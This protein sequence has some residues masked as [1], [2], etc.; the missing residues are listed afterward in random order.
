MLTR[1][2]YLAAG[3]FIISFIGL[4]L[5]GTRLRQRSLFLSLAWLAFVI[6][7]GDGWAILTFGIPEEIL[8]FSIIAAVAGLM[9]I[10]LLHSWN[11][12]GQ[13]VWLTSILVTIL[14]IS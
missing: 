14:F 3:W 11:A 1:S 10:I 9:I 12:F 7:I 2:L 13:V 8:R 4:L 5:G 6:M